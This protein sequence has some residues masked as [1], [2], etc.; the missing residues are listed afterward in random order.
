MLT[1]SPVAMPSPSFG[2]AESAI[3][4]SPVVTP[5]RTCRPRVGSAAFSSP[6]ASRAATAARTPRSGLSSCASGAPKRATTASPMNFST[7]PP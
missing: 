5:I 2:R 3:I 6:R 7:V 1:T 4:A